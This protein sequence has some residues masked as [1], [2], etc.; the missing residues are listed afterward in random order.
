MGTSA[1]F[2]ICQSL[3]AVKII[4][5]TSKVSP[6]TH[7]KQTA[8]KIFGVPLE[9]LEQEGQ[10][11]DDIPF[12]VHDITEYLNEFGLKQQGLFR[13]SGSVNK[14]KHLKEK[15]D[16]GN[17]VNLTKDG[18]PESAASLL[19]L[20]LRELPKAVIPD[21]VHDNIIRTFQDNRNDT[22]E[23][24]QQ[25]KQSLGCL[26]HV[27]YSLLEYLCKFLLKVSSYSD[28]NSMTLENLA[29]VFGPSI[30]FVPISPK[31]QEEQMLCNALLLHILQHTEIFFSEPDGNKLQL[32]QEV[33][34]EPQDENL[35]L[36][37][38]ASSV[39]TSSNDRMSP[40]TEVLMADTYI[41]AERT[42][43]DI[44]SLSF[45]ENAIYQH[46]TQSIESLGTR[47]R[48]LL[49]ARERR[50]LLKQQEDF[51]RHQTMD[52]T[53]KENYPC[54][55]LSSE[56]TQMPFLENSLHHVEKKM[57]DNK[58]TFALY[59]V[60]QKIPKAGS[61][62][63][64]EQIQI[65]DGHQEME[66]I[67]S[68]L[69]ETHHKLDWTATEMKQLQLS[70]GIESK[71]SLRRKGNTKL[72]YQK[73][74][75]DQVHKPGV[76]DRSQVQG[77]KDPVS[78]VSRGGGPNDEA[79]AGEP[80]PAIKAWQEE[81]SPKTETL[82]STG[83]NILLH[84]ITDGDKP[85]PSPRCS[86]FSQSQRFNSDPESA[87][88]PPSTQQFVMS[89][90]PSR[91][92]TENDKG[93]STVMQ[94]TKHIQNLK[95]KIRKYEEKFEHEKKYK[96]SYT[97]KVSNPEVLKWMNDLAKGRKHLK[98]LKLK[99]SDAENS[100]VK[101]A[102]CTEQPAVL[103]TFS[104]A[105]QQHL[106]DTQHMPSVAETAETVMKRFREK[107]QLLGLPE[108]FKEMTHK[109]LALEKVILQ[110]SLLYFE[111]IHGR[112]A[113]KNERYLMKPLYDRYRIIKQLLMTSPSIPTI[114][115]E[116]GSDEE[117]MQGSPEMPSTA[118]SAISFDDYLCTMQEDSEPAFV[119]PLEEKKDIKQPALS[120]SNLHEASMTELLEHLRQTR[121]DKKRLRKALREFEEQFLKQTGRSAQKED[122]I[123]MAEEYYEYK[124]I[125]AKLR[126]LEVLISKQDVAKTI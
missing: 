123:P 46:D 79:N 34:P 83:T 27:H 1:S 22:E 125:K 33:I 6:E 96:P 85:L 86:S 76:E 100:T 82:Q 89:R 20:F 50:R 42:A 115:E 88:S 24:C 57:L 84:H 15:Y 95:R 126:L 75:K 105:E 119:S 12:I 80:V 102:S 112:P 113:T 30:F 16:Q 109:Q 81:P 51:C 77:C 94:L 67:M 39:Q 7:Q 5:N 104:D 97:D 78:Q 14:V 73:E 49:S 122:R 116:E 23:C 71:E 32:V 2:S 60:V 55:V 25:I 62:A 9:T 37:S 114:E 110:K 65:Q 18:E 99:M 87:P 56:E 61:H 64:K 4:G 31:S 111:S 21:N 8:K 36:G 28:Y 13:V 124:N 90:S 38:E 47:P 45:E 107:R 101:P 106:A 69:T 92:N 26:P 58:D 10:M 68:A 118:C 93:L 108:S 3:S 52:D 98:E 70:H 54:S 74:V 120:M 41:N 63:E 29:K 19:K 59:S 40:T 91:G 11:Q 66:N 17:Q 35:I 43:E 117:I 121:A 44:D 53:N 48:P 72:L 103:E